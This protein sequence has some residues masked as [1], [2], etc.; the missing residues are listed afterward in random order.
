M[1]TWV[2]RHVKKLIWLVLYRNKLPRDLRRL[3]IQRHSI[4]AQ[5]CMLAVHT[6]EMSAIFPGG[7]S[8][9]SPLTL[10]RLVH[11]RNYPHVDLAIIL[12][13]KKQEPIPFTYTDNPWRCTD[14]IRQPEEK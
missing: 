2:Y 4:I 10:L 6:R 14:H 3:F 7:W 9:I 1:D 11:D 12:A 5:Y 8:N 13:V